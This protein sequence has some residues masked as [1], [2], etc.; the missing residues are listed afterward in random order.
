MKIIPLKDSDF[1]LVELRDSGN[2]GRDTPHCNLHG[3]MNNF[4]ADGI[5]RCCSTYRWID[6]KKDHLKAND[7]LA[8]CQESH[9][10][11][12]NIKEE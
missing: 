4:T 10:G 3:A 8:G 11:N 5:W 6:Y 7:C 1:S 12:A 2:I 9:V